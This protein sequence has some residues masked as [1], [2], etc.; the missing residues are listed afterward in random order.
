MSN[1]TIRMWMSNVTNVTF[2]KD[3]D[4]QCDKDVDVQCD[5]SNVTM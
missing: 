4:V 2:D 5:M 1:V 3:V